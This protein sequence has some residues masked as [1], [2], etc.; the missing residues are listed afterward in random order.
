MKFIF[1]IISLQTV[2]NLFFYGETELNF[3][4]GGQTKLITECSA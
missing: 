3:I 1:I 2:E 4:K